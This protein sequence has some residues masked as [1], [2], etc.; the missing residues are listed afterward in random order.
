[1][2]GESRVIASVFALAAFI[3][4]LAAGVL[5]GNEGSVI[6]TR[7]LLAMIV[8]QLLGMFAGMAV[9]HVVGQHVHRYQVEHPAPDIVV[10]GDAEVKTSTG[11]NDSKKH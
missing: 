3:V 7:A 6:L 11:S 10:Q 4:A 2:T 9:E 8:C 1:M 5:A